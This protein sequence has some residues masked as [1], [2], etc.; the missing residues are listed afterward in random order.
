MCCRAQLGTTVASAPRRCRRRL[1]RPTLPMAARCK[2]TASSFTR[3]DTSWQARTRELTRSSCSSWEMTPRWCGP[4]RWR[5]PSQFYPCQGSTPTPPSSLLRAMRRRGPVGSRRAS[6]I[7]ASCG[8]P[9][10]ATTALRRGARVY[11]DHVVGMVG[12]SRPGLASLRRLPAEPPL[13]QRN[14]EARPALGRARCCHFP[15]CRSH[16]G[17]DPTNHAGTPG[18]ENGYRQQC[19]R[20]IGGGGDDEDRTPAPADVLQLVR[21]GHEQGGRSLGRV[22]QSRIGGG[23]L[24]TERIRRGCR[25]QAIDLAPGKEHEAAQ[26]YEPEWVVTPQI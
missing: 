11:A 7:W 19:R 2:A 3:Q 21:V 15:G 1:Q 5:P 10:R 18:F 9:G 26:E 14:N 13:S 6:N 23:K 12:R 22:E 16:L 25:K 8:W 17:V 20:D 4:R 24:G